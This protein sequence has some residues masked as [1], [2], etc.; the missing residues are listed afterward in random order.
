M[1]SCRENASPP[2]RDPEYVHTVKDA[3]RGALDIAELGTKTESGSAFREAVIDRVAASVPYDAALLHALSPRV[4]LSTGAL[5]G[6]DAAELERSMSSWDDFAVELGRF[7]DLALQSGGVVTDRQALPP[8]GPQR[9]LF[10]GAFGGRKKAKAA[11]FVHL[12]VRG[13][14]VAALV[15]VRFKDVPFT[16]AEVAWLRTVAPTLAVADTYHQVL[17][18]AQR[19]SVATELKCADSRLS[20]AHRDIVERVALGHTNAQIAE[21]IGK[22]PNTVRNQLAEVM[23]RIGASN[24]ADVVRLAVLR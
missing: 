4:P 9:K 14:I 12:V 18:R 21:A 6:L 16:D 20:Q 23:R 3:A 15:L 2:K 19:A 17:D 22:S 1:T 5:R 8:K 11:A 10:E 7:R 13:R 24:R